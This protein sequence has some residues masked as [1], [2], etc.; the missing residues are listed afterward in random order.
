MI[1]VWKMRSNGENSFPYTVL[2]QA[3]F[4]LRWWSAGEESVCSAGDPGSIPESGRSAGEGLG[5]PF[6]HS[7]AS[8]VTQLVKNPPAV[9]ETWI[10]SLG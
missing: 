6:E 8:L 2:C 10:Q 3:S 7:W 4:E 5:Y 9:W 1:A